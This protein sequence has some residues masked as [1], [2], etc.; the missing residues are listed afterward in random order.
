MQPPASLEVCTLLKPG[1]IEGELRETSLDL[2]F[3]LPSLSECSGLLSLGSYC[4]PSPCCSFISLNL[5]ASVVLPGPVP[6][7]PLKLTC[8]GSYTSSSS[9]LC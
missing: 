4:I 6:V 5:M 8:P 7:P 3:P 1:L 9:D 2:L